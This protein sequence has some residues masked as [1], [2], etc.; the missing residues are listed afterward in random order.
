MSDD[1]GFEFDDVVGRQML[2]GGLSL[3]VR[4][5]SPGK[6]AVSNL[7]H[8]HPV[9][10]GHGWQEP[11]PQPLVA[12]VLPTVQYYPAVAREE[13][14]VGLEVVRCGHHRVNSVRVLIEE[15]LEEPAFV[16]V[17][18]ASFRVPWL[19]LSE[20]GVRVTQRMVDGLE[21]LK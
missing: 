11:F 9:E 12:L 8:R 19:H 18:E 13:V 10:R 20:H 14:V 5:Y 21:A 6:E 4:A 3:S 7:T 1:L 2:S 15:V 16:Q 17:V